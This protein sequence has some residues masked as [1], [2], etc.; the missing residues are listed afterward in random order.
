MSEDSWACEGCE[1]Y[2]PF[3]YMAGHF[4]PRCLFDRWQAAETR[5][6]AAEAR[7]AALRDGAEVLYSDLEAENARLREALKLA[8]DYFD[9][10]R[11]PEVKAKL[12]A[13]LAA[14]DVPRGGEENDD[15]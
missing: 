2:L 3:D 4:C 12:R 14:A 9:G 1:R 13:A 6:E 11:F 5:A 10:P 7:E 15:A 8:I